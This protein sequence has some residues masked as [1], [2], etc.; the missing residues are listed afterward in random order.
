MLQPFA[1]TLE[2]FVQHCWRS[3]TSRTKT[4]KLTSFERAVGWAW[5][6]LWFS[7]SIPPYAKGLV[8]A[9]ITGYDSEGILRLGQQHA[10]DLFHL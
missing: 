5:T 4:D 8:Y 2:D 10:A 7:W 3:W 9:R 1:I 6:F